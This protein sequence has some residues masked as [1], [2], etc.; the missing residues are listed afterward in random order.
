MVFIYLVECVCVCVCVY[1][2]HIAVGTVEDK[3][4]CQIPWSGV[5]DSW[6]TSLMDAGEPTWVHSKNNKCF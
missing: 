5:I 4:R 2:C 1:E 6:E 3:R